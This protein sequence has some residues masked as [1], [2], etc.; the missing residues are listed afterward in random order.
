MK[1]TALPVSPTLKM[2]KL[3]ENISLFILIKENVAKIFLWKKK[4][5]NRDILREMAKLSFN[6]PSVPSDLSS[7]D[8]YLYS[9]EA[10]YGNY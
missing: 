8:D 9:K 1:N 7:N 6:D 3:S 5:T 2:S 10:H 4:K